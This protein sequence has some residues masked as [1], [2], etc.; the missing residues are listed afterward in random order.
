M[1]M[2][3]SIRIIKVSNGFLVIKENIEELWIR[4][5]DNLHYI[6]EYDVSYKLR[7]IMEEDN[8]TE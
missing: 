4:P 3:S 1:K 7:D 6:Q 5:E 2:F 8:A